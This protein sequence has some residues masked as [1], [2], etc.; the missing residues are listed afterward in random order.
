MQLKDAPAGEASRLEYGMARLQN[1]LLQF[2]DHQPQTT[3]SR[4][5]PHD[6][7]VG[8]RKEAATALIPLEL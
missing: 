8:L 3:I 1:P 6:P 2:C 4:W 7:P 5:G